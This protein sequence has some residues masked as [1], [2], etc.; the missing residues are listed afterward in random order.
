MRPVRKRRGVVRYEQEYPNH[1]RGVFSLDEYEDD[2]G[3]Q[4]CLK[5]EDNDGEQATSYREVMKSK[6]KDQWLEAMKSEMKLLEMQKTWK[7]VDIPQGQSAI[8]CKWIFQIERNPN[9]SINKFMRDSWPRDY[10]V[11]QH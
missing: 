10:A 8:G 11:T 4:Y 5:A 6:Y 7:L 3:A 1:P 2:F 9:G